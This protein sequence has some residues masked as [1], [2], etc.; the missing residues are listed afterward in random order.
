MSDD[1]ESEVGYKKPPKTSQFQKGK[2]GN[3]G[4]RTKQ[5]P[6][7]ADVFRKIS[8]Q[9]VR[10][11]G[12]NGPLCMTKLEAGMTQLLNKAASGDLRATKILVQFAN[13]FQQ[14]DG[15]SKDKFVV[16]FREV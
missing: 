8:K 11:N 14:G 9:K 16:E 7:I 2:S 15:D 12:P 3:P 1:F 10:T 13:R 5:E 6:D 4:G